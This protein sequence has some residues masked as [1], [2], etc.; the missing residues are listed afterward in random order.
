M[1]RDISRF[2]K[3]SYDLLVIG[4]GING[5]AIAHL[6]SRRGKKVALLEKADFASGASSKSTK[7][8]HGGIRYLENFEFDLVR[9]SLKERS[10]Q[11]QAAPHLVK[12][13]GFVI[14]VY[15]GDLRP[16][17]LM[18]F[19]VFL[20]ELI[21]GR[22]AVGKRRNLSVKDVLSLEP[23]L[24]TEGLLGGVM[25]DDAQMDDARL[26]LENVL[27]ACEYGAH[28]ANYAE[29]LSFIKEKGKVVGVKARD[30]LGGTHFDVFAQK[31]VCAVGP[32]TN[33]LLRL[34]HP[35]AKKRVRTTKGI[36]LVYEDPISNHALLLPSLRD[37][38]IFFVIPWMGHSLIGT[39]DTSYIGDPD[40]VEAAEEDVDY[41]FNETKRIFPERRLTRDKIL[42]TFA[43]LRPLVR[44]WGSP[45]KISRRH[46]FYKTESGLIFVVGGKYTTYRKIAEECVNK[47]WRPVAKEE[48]T[49]Y[50]GGTIYEKPADLAIKYN[51]HIDLIKGLMAKYGTRYVDVLRLAET[52]IKL[53][54]K[55]SEKPPVIRAQLVYSA[56]VEMACKAD[57]I[58][59]RRLGLGYF[60][61]V[62]QACLSVIDQVIRETEGG[63]S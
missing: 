36:H 48:F 38:R 26:C 4:G 27:S 63:S 6:A 2:Q 49:V 42:T 46:L 31:V 30:L 53:M 44:K 18:R 60:G 17:W 33:E 10:I 23:G 13:L 5:A 47:L 35:Q 37:K 55:V 7:L 12:P 39:T 58:V 41:L 28:A 22:Y 29:V 20:Y 62:S 21:A 19:G 24:K 54:E 32:W 56:K 52:D 45:S 59:W 34:D 51:L 8:I 9:E 15:K 43:G 11:L 14:P 50:G 40:H 57:D 25:Y 1:L 16:L 61:N 3:T